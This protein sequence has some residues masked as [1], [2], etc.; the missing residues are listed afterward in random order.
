MDKIQIIATTGS[1]ILLVFII[2]LIRNRRLKEEYSLLWLL[3]SFLFL[4]LSIWKEGLDWMAA[5]VGISYAPAALFLL[6]IMSVFI[7]LIE[8]SLIISK[9]SEWIKQSAQDIG[10]MKLEMSHLVETNV[11]LSKDVQKVSMKQKEKFPKEKKKE[12]KI[13]NLKVN[14]EKGDNKKPQF[15]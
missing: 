9:Q 13:I 2:S 15:S 7:M 1:V 8:M 5:Q 10:I 12:N 6:L 3:F 4:G 11:E 14:K